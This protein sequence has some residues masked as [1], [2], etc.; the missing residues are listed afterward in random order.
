MVGIYH[1]VPEIGYRIQAILRNIRVSTL[2][3]GLR[4]TFAFSSLL[5]YAL[6][7]VSTLKK[8]EEDEDFF[9]RRNERVSVVR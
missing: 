1:D 9:K 2:L 5:P 7:F 6:C 8:A 3:R 4:E